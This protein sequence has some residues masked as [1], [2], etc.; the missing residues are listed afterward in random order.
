MSTRT[1]LATTLAL[2]PLTATAAGQTELWRVDAPSPDA[3]YARALASA[4]DVNGDGVGD[5]VVGAPEAQLVE[6]LSGLDGSTL[7]STTGSP[8]FGYDVSGGVDMDD[9]GVPDVAVGAPHF[10]DGGLTVLSSATGATILES[11]AAGCTSI[12]SRV[13]E[14]L[15]DLTGDGIPEIAI[16]SDQAGND[17]PGVTSILNEDPQ[18]PGSA[19][20]T[21]TIGDACNCWCESETG[22]ALARVGDVNGNGYDDFALTK[23]WMG[24]GLFVYGGPNL[25][26]L[27]QRSLSLPSSRNHVAGVGDVDGDGRPD[28]AVVARITFSLNRLRIYGGFGALKYQF[29]TIAESVVGVG[30]ANADGYDDYL[31][32][33]PEDATVGVDAGAAYLHSGIDGALLATFYGE[34]AG[35]RF[36]MSMAAIGDADGD[37]VDDFAIGA[38]YSGGGFF[39]DGYVIAFSA[40][41]GPQPLTYCTAKVSSTGC[42]PHVDW[43][44]TPTITGVDDFL[45]LARDTVPGK[46]GLFFWGSSGSVAVP[47]LGGTLCVQPGLT[48]TGIQVAPGTASCDGGYAFH[49]SQSYMNAQGVSAGDT[50]NGQFWSRDPD[51]PDGTGVG[52][53]DA[54]EFTAWP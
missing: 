7:L 4:G 16:S 3:Q 34:A 23:N 45:V 31:L 54:I 44:G 32:G 14:L 5:L 37:G 29:D 1:P 28:I 6:I 21:L 8:L 49:F 40:P 43:S 22:Y 15:G 17:F 48:R 53:T 13:V 38:P 51:H 20:E 11:S 30:D 50:V 52:L 25:S 24:T 42:L 46:P 12:S 39:G 35:D 26:L 36:G 19:I 27:F 2:L 9:D 33:A 18:A 10:T 41:G 47:F